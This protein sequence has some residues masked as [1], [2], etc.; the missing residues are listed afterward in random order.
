MQLANKAFEQ[1]GL[2]AQGYT[3]R[4][5]E[6][7]NDKDADFMDTDFD[8]PIEDGVNYRVLVMQKGQKVENLL[9]KSES[10]FFRSPQMSKWLRIRERAMKEQRKLWHAS[11]VKASFRVLVQ[12]LDKWQ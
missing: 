11:R 3:W 9:K 1:S 4:Q 6:K 10:F 5:V 7:Q 8:D 12:M 2:K